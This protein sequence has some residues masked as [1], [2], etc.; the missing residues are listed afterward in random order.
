MTSLSDAAAPPRFLRTRA[1]VRRMFANRA[2]MLGFVLFGFICLATLLA[3]LI[4]RLDPNALSIRDRFQPPSLQFPLGT[5]NLGRDMLSRVLY[6]AR[7]SLWIGLCVIVL[8][9]VFG[10]LLGALAGYYRRLDNI[11]MR[12]ADALMAFPA[13]LLAIGI[14]AALGPSAVTAIIALAVVYI[15]RTARVVRASILVVRELDYVQAARA[16]GATDYRILMRHI[17]P[18]CMAPLIVQLSF[19]FAYAIL[20]EAVLSFLGLGAPPTVPSWGI[21]ISEGRSYLREAAWLTVVPGLAIAI[22]VLGLNLLGDG[23]RD[24]LDPRMKVEQG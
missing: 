24:V 13:V 8:N 9:A 7:L 15:P 19:V 10:V 17:L 1:L 14:A 3:P 16:A 4:T 12:I 6:G 20:S 11:L 23:L 21:L 5:D 22:T 18:N 2:F